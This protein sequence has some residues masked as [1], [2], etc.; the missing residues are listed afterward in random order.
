[1]GVISPKLLFSVFLLVV[2]FYIFP[3]KAS[4]VFPE[5]SVVNILSIKREFMGPETNRFKFVFRKEAENLKAYYLSHNYDILFYIDILGPETLSTSYESYERIG[6]GT[7][8]GEVTHFGREPCTII[9][10]SEHG[11]TY[12]R[13]W[14]WKSPGGR[15]R[16]KLDN[17][18]TQT[19]FRNTV[20][21]SKSL[22][23][24]D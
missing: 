15:S 19:Q 1:M 8:Q 14:T 21:T 18:L 10:V 13:Q 6:E 3:K 12:L 9:F 11:D 20:K 24:V 17:I 5:G 22:P 4:A 23:G 7:F 2:L 16:N